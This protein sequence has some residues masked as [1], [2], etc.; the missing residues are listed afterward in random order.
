MKKSFGAT[1]IAYPTPVWVVGTYG[2]DKK[3]NLMTVAWGGIV[4]S[5]PP[6]LSISVRKSRLTYE[7]IM[8]KKCFTINVATEDF[9]KEADL[10]GIISGKDVNKFAQCKLTPAKSDLIDAPFIREFPL[11]VECRL[12]KD[13]DLGSHTLFIG[14]IMDVKAEIEITDEKGQISIELLR[15]LIFAPSTITYHGVGGCFGQAYTLGKSL[16]E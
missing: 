8:L 6:C 3:P 12:I 14:R 15:P 16:L 4:C 9:A 5:N 1:T 2:K 7:N 13:A 11:V 10:C